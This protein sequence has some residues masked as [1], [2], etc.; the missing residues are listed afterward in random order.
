ML[1]RMMKFREPKLQRED[2]R[3]E[4]ARWQIPRVVQ[5]GD[6]D[7]ESRRG[8]RRH[9]A[10]IGTR[11]CEERPNCVSR[12]NV[13]REEPVRHTPGDIGAVLLMRKAVGWTVLFLARYTRGDIGMRDFR[14]LRRIPLSCGS[15]VIENR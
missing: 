15:F 13:R 14:R 1:N 4:I 7:S 10:A 2:I 3:R 12:Q 8:S 9:P 5:R 6:Q 11:G